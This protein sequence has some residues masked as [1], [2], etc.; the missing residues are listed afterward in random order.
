MSDPGKLIVRWF[1]EVWNRGNL[2][3]VSEY[4]T[5][6]SKIHD[7]R[8][9]IQ[10]AQGFHDYYAQMAA[11][12]SEV[13]VTPLELIVSGDMASLRWSATLK[14]TGDG[15]GLPATGKTFSVTGISMARYT[16]E[17][18]LDEA[19]QNWDMMGLLEQI[20]EAEPSKL[21]LGAR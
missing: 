18:K 9:S 17:G 15:L 2:E 19:W 20:R 7:G 21:Y 6:T 3:V 16:A 14:H 5:P 11:S 12:F 13:R 1:E 8:M 10:G 4:I